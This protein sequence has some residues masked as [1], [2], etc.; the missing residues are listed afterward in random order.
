MIEVTCVISTKDRY[1]ST[2]PLV[3][4]AICNQTYK[5]K[6]V[7]I[8]DDG[9]QINLSQ[10]PLYKHIFKM[11]YCNG[12]SD[13]GVVL[14]GQRKGQVA[15]H[16][17]SLENSKTL[18]IWRLDD[19]TVPEPDV[20]EKLVACIADDVGAVG[21]CVI[22]SMDSVS[23]YASNKIED[24]YL[25]VNE[26]WYIHDKDAQPKEV[27]HLYS[28]FLYRKSIAEY[29]K[30]LSLIGHR[31]ET[32]LTY[33]MK[34]KGFKNI[35]QPQAKTW[36]F[37]NPDGGIRSNPS[38]RLK[39]SQSD[40]I[41]FSKKMKSWGV[42]PNEYSFVVLNCGLGDHFAFKSVLH[43]YMEKNRYKKNIFF[44]TFPEVFKD[45]SN[46]TLASI[47]QSESMFGSNVDNFN[48]YKFMIENNWDKSLTRAYYDMYQLNGEYVR[49][50]F[51]SSDLFYPKGESIIISPYSHSSDNAK[52]YPYWERLVELIKDEGF[53]V[54]QIGRS[55]E[56]AIDGIDEYLWDLPLIDL[57]ARVS[58]CKLWIGVDNFLQHMVN[59][60]NEVVPGIVIWGESNPKLFGYH[61]NLNILKSKKYLRHDQF[62]T[63][64]GRPRN[65]EAFHDANSLFLKI[66]ETLVKSKDG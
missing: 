35:F 63:W 25:G 43:L 22:N 15:N 3:L 61:Y 38:E 41:E 66:R 47:A 5:P 57:Q 29:P 23:P 8:Y 53:Q 58:C 64:I 44:V 2:L 52:S 13:G 21:G 28:S 37:E 34:R 51:G 18:Y 27:D 26:Q 6:H 16:I 46:I 1:R 14:F 33:E 60:M 42:K 36:H 19:D 31:E 39:L 56:Y 12:I 10:D 7:L 50:K 49:G 55:G 48:V 59:S 45:I 54:I 65:I 17:K 40:E 20:L 9:E 4:V 24:I 11:M 62:G 32:I 30:N